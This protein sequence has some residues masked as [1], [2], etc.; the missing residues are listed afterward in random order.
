MRQ[1]HSRHSHLAVK[2]VEDK[3]NGPAVADALKQEVPGIVLV[4]PEGGKI[5]RAFAA[6]PTL[7]AGNVY[8]PNPVDP[9]TGKLIPERAWVQSFIKN[10]EVFPKGLHDDDV[11]A[12][13]QLVTYLRGTH[14]AMLDYLKQLKARDAKKADQEAGR[15]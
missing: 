3:A 8:L 4:E 7:K 2:L 11:D 5:A 6:Q 10:C 9:I 12:F 1:W 13:T 15:A 14:S